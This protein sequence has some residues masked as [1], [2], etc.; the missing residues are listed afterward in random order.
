MGSPNRDSRRAPASYSALQAS[1]LPTTSSQAGDVPSQSPMLFL[2]KNVPVPSSRASSTSTSLSSQ[3]HHHLSER[4]RKG[5]ESLRELLPE[6][7]VG[8]LIAN[9]GTFLFTM[10]PLT[11]RSRLENLGQLF[12]PEN[13]TIIALRAPQVLLVEEHSLSVM[14]SDRTEFLRRLLPQC[15]PKRIMLKVP[16]LIYQDESQTLSIYQNLQK[17]LPSLDMGKVRGI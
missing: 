9:G 1:T 7:D 16:A 5:L 4:E 2:D 10:E 14:V 17:A 8:L 13:A 3:D 6:L 12:S 15:A 11:I